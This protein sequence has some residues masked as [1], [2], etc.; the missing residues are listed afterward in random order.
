MTLTESQYQSILA[1]LTK[2]ERAMNDVITAQ[3]QMVT[4]EQVNE[5]TTVLQ[6]DI[7]AVTEL[8]GSLQTRGESL[9]AEPYEG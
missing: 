7:D 9:E 4:N 1:R 6:Q 3:N 5:L 2:L 8:I